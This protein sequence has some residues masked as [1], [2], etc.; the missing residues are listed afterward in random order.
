VAGVDSLRRSRVSLV[1]Q[2]LLGDVM[3]A[4]D[5]LVSGLFWFMPICD[6]G[7]NFS[8]EVLSCAQVGSS[9]LLFGV[10][11]MGSVQAGGG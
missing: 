5:C 9:S 6:G 7:V 1:M 11:G 10:C 3:H 2:L 4:V 8:S